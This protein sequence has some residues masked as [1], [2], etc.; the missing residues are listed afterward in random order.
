MDQPARDPAAVVRKPMRPLKTVPP[1]MPAA[2][3][4]EPD[5]LLVIEDVINN[6]QFERR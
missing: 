2:V 5:G 6:L 4:Y 1:A 3:P